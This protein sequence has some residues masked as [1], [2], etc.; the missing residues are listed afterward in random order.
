M[1]IATKNITPPCQSTRVTHERP[2]ATTAKSGTE[3]PH[4]N[5]H[6][7]RFMR[8]PP[9]TTVL[10][11]YDLSSE[12]GPKSHTTIIVPLGRR[13]SAYLYGSLSSTEM[14]LNHQI[15]IKLDAM[16]LHYEMTSEQKIKPRTWIIKV[17]ERVQTKFFVNNKPN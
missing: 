4:Y 9:T 2:A 5:P 15:H 11:G 17:G 13:E 6:Y 1:H 16:F 7:E 14:Y 10:P 12:M 3:A 8:R